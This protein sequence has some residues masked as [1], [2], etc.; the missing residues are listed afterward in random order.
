M[1]DIESD[2]ESENKIEE[3]DVDYHKQIHAKHDYPKQLKTNNEK[4][5]EKKYDEF[6]NYSNFH[7]TG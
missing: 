7:D 5:L 1:L 4:L 2:S 6:P 3:I